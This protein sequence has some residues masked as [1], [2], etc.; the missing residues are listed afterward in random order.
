MGNASHEPGDHP[1]N[2]GHHQWLY[3]LGFVA[4]VALV[5]WISELVKH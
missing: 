5:A 1:H 3:V 4:I 2:A